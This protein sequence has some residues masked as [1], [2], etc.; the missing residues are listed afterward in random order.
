MSYY[1]FI[2]FVA[3]LFFLA[4]CTVPAHLSPLGKGQVSVLSKENF[5]PIFKGDFKSFLFKT[6][7]SYGDKFELGGMLMLKQVSEGNYRTIF[8]TKFGMTLFDF[9]FG[10]NGFIVHKTLEQFDKKIFL[11]IIEQDI[12]M[13]LARGL[14]GN[15]V[16][17]FNSTK[18]QVLK[19]KISNKTHYLVQENS[20]H[21][22]EIHQGK[23]VS[24]KLSKY[25]VNI[26]HDIDIQH[27]DIPL[28]MSLFLMKH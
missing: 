3:C 26:P 14:M 15:K 27:H 22:T 8:L 5:N 19:T 24:V 6:N 7:M 23:K 21:L 2:L 25:V 10:Q 17:I 20:K 13:L 12:E 4:S 16:T 28:K 11:K 1:K 9:E 18:N